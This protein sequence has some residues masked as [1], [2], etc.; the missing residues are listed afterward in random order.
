MPETI[1][2][3]RADRVAHIM[4]NRPERMNAISPLL[5]QELD[6]AFV[7][8][9]TD[10]A[11]SVIL[12]SGAGRGFCAGYDLAGSGDSAE[13]RGVSA[14]RDRL[15]R[16]IER[17]LRIWETRIPVIAKVHGACLAGGSMLA[18][19]SDIT[20]AAE[21]ARVGTPQIPLGAGFLG[22]LW[23]WHVGPKKAKELIFPTGTV[24]S[25]AEAARIGLFNVAVPA[26]ELDSYVEEYAQRVAKTPREILVLEK[27]AINRS[28]E[29]QGFR[30][31]FLLSA[32]YDALAHATDAVRQT[33]Q[34][35]QQEG[36][37]SALAAWASTQ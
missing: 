35:I 16:M 37:K 8:A 29:I 4:L 28:Q 1:T 26:T 10:D 24:I 7:E 12:L 33:K 34:R 30:E 20:I 22:P 25:G 32:E 31:A 18:V 17:F 5:Q 15:E 19:S 21:D 11:V 3:E 14:D 27:R 23:A 36:L 13:I 2:Y 6:H 9:E